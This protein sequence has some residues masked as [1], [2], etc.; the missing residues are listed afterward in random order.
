MGGK[1]AMPNEWR[2]RNNSA[3][4]QRKMTCG[5]IDEKKI[6]KQKLG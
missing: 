6:G 2:K 3:A 1:P 4:Y 5:G